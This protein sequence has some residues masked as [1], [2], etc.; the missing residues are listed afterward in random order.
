M[1]KMWNN[2]MMPKIYNPPPFGYMKVVNVPSGV[3]IGR[4]IGKDGRVFIAISEQTDGILYIWYNK[5]SRQI[6]IY[7]TIMSGII[8]AVNKVECRMKFCSAIEN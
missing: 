3:C 6:E 7:G 4:V 5:M 2:K 8:D 1:V